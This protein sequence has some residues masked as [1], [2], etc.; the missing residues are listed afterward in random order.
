MSSYCYRIDGNCKYR[1]EEDGCIF[2]SQGSGNEIDM[3][4]YESDNTISTLY[5]LQDICKGLDIHI[6]INSNCV[7]FKRYGE[8][9]NKAYGY[10]QAFS[11][12]DIENRLGSFDRCVDEYMTK[13]EQEK[14]ILKETQKN[15]E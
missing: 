1:D 2:Y 3:P 6:E 8:I 9:N 4:C 5:K 14:E 11:L 15:D 7:I 10:N 13:L 12:F